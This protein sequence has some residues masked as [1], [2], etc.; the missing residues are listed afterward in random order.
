[1]YFL[2]PFLSDSLV[3]H[4]VSR[5]KHIPYSVHGLS[6]WQRVERNGLFLA[7]Q[8]GISSNLV[9]CFALFHDSQRINDFHDPG[10]GLRGAQFARECYEEGRLAITGSEMD[11]LFYA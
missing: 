10:H 8:E 2:N 1:M 4:V 11:D 9:S 7:A 5:K 3:E 6:H